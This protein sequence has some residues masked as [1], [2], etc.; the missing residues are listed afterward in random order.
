MGN[1]SSHLRLEQRRKIAEWLEAKMPVA[2]VA[3]RRGRDASP[4]YRDIKRNRDI[5]TELPELNGDY[6]I[7]A[8]AILA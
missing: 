7:S 3:D 5:D 2:E 6:A 4:I 1:R 8:Q